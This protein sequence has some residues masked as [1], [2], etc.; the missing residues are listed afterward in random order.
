MRR[1]LYTYIYVHLY[2]EIHL[3]WLHVDK[4][5]DKTTVTIL[6]SCTTLAWIS[7]SFCDAWFLVTTDIVEHHYKIIESTIPAYK[8]CT[9]NGNGAEQEVKLG[10]EWGE[11]VVTFL[12]VP[13][14]FVPLGRTILRDIVMYFFK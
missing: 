12:N 4:D 9:D 8:C 14:L 11:E 13:H 10:E 7:I 6:F 5:L 1:F 2:E 3:Q